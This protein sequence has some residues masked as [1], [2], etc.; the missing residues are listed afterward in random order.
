MRKEIELGGSNLALVCNSAT[1][2]IA[3]RLFKCDFMSFLT[4]SKDVPMDEKLEKLEEIVYVMSL[5]A[6]MSTTDALNA[7]AD[8]FIEWVAGFDMDVM[9]SIIVPQALELWTSNIDSSSKPKNVDAPQ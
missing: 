7:N 9:I 1:P 3:K 2:W 8:G 4:D 5:Q 6:N